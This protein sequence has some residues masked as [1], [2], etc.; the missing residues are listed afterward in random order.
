MLVVTIALVIF[1]ELSKIL[2]MEG[3]SVVGC[4]QGIESDW[5]GDQYQ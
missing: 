4:A 5:L 2:A 1:S 3:R